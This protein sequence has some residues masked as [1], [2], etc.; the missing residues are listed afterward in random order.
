MNFF[1]NKAIQ[2]FIFVLVI[3][4]SLMLT[5]PKKDN[6]QKNNTIDQN[7]LSSSLIINTAPAQE[8]ILEL[9]FNFKGQSALARELNGETIFYEL[10]P[11]Q[12]WPIASLTKLM[13]G[14]IALEKIEKN[15]QIENLIKAMMLI[16]DNDA[17]DQLANI[18]GNENFIEAM[19]QKAN[20]LGMYQTSFFDPSGLSFLNQSTTNDLYKLVRYISIY[21]P[22]ILQWSRE[23]ELNINGLKYVNINKFVERSDFLGGKTGWTDEAS[24]NLISV[25]SSPQKPILI[26]ALGTANK[27]E[28]FEQTKN[29]LEWI[30]Q[31]YKL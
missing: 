11:Q 18:F 19:N 26:I 17:A 2:P 1:R 22:Q 31:Y 14:V 12:R 10:N 29:L 24:G 4:F 8:P 21:R 20:E 16:S 23:R 3:L 6:F 9:P 25:F 27:I 5:Q 13:T 7:I 30:F 15:N 28:R